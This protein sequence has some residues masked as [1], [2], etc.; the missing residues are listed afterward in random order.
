MRSAWLRTI[1][2]L[3]GQE[4]PGGPGPHLLP[5]HQ[6]SSC[7]L[8]IFSVSVSCYKGNKVLHNF[9]FKSIPIHDR[10]RSSFMSGDRDVKPLPVKSYWADP[11]HRANK[12]NIQW[13]LASP[14]SLKLKWGFSCGNISSLA[15]T[16][17]AFSLA[18]WSSS[19]L[20]VN[21]IPSIGWSL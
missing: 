10:E 16:H 21:S 12:T 6:T 13:G 5:P 18:K 2:V 8:P 11:S 20:A 19:L 7:R 15:L 1:M 17:K 9:L 14:L 4:G 3:G